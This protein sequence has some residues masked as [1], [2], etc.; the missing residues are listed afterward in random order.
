MK[1]LEK[2]EKMYNKNENK[3][4]KIIDNYDLIR[5]SYYRI[6]NIKFI[7]EKIT[8]L[9]NHDFHFEINDYSWRGRNVNK[10]AVRIDNN[11]QILQVTC[12]CN[13]FKENKSCVHLAGVFIYYSDILFKENIDINSFSLD[14][15]EK[16]SKLNIKEIK[17][18][19]F[20]EVY[21]KSIN[22]NYYYNN[23]FEIKVKI[24][25]NKMYSYGG[26]QSNFIRAY[27]NENIECK[28]G[29]DFIYNKNKNY[30]NP[31]NEIIIEYINNNFSNINTHYYEGKD[32]IKLINKLLENNINFY[33][34]DT[35]ITNIIEEFP[36]NTLIDKIEDNKYKIKFDIDNYIP[37]TDDYKYIFYNDNIYKLSI[38]NRLLVDDL[39]DNDIDNIIVPKEKLELF[40]KSLLPII[41]NNTKVNDNIKEE[42][43][44]I[45]KP[46][47]KLYFDLK[48]KSISCLVK[49]VYNEEINYFDN[50]DN[51]L[52]DSE[53]EQEVINDLINLGF[54]IDNKNKE[55]YIN[56]IENMIEFK[57][58][59]LNI[60]NDKYQVFTTE[61]FD[62]F[63]IYKPS[64]KSM[65]SIG[66][67]NILKY[68]FDLGDID[69]NEIVNI[70]KEIKEKK[71][72]YRLKNGDVLSLEDDKLNELV[73][74]TE[75]LEITDD[76]II[77][78]KGSILKYRAIYLD[79]IKKNKYH[80]IETDN[81]FND[82]IN[83][84][85]KYKDSNIKL[86]D[87]DYKLL[88]DYQVT[89]IKWLYNLDKT[90]FGGIL[91][92]EMGLGKT[93]QTIY[94]IK[95]ILKED[96][97][98]KFLIV[99]PTS[100][101]YNWEHEFNTFAKEIKTT[102]VLG[103]K[104]KRKSLINNKNNVFI[105]TYGLIREDEE[106]YQDK[107]YHAIII[108]EAQNIKNP[109][110]QST[111]AIKKINSNVKF[112]L[113]GTPLENSTIELWSIFDF[114]MPGYLS[115]SKKFNNKYKIND[116]NDKTNKLI[117]GLSNQITPFILR[118]LKKDVIKELP[119]KLENNIYIDLSEGQ[120]K[121]YVA[122]LEKVRKKIDEIIANGQKDK[123]K[124]LILPLL[125]K[126]R[127]I[128]IDP[129]IVYEDYND[130]SNKIDRF[131]SIV[132]ESIK[133][134]H[135]ILVFTSYKS[136]LKIAKEELKK[137]GID[138]LV[139]DGD[140]NAKDRM[141][142]VNSFNNDENAPK[143][144]LIMLKAGGTGL[145]LA[146]ADIVIHLDLWWNPQAENQA[147]DRA[148]RI[149]QK[150]VVNV[151]RL[152]SKGTIEEKVLELQEKK[153]EL[154]NKLLDSN[155]KDQNILST[156][157]EKDILNLL[158]YENK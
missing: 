125:T 14:L 152:I 3:I 121:I 96:K 102:L 20:I 5:G 30:F 93:L 45:N 49:F 120:K 110:A 37:I 135:K 107:E 118:R 63:K 60:L 146:T 157:T 134:N 89:G 41:K 47:C 100:L 136:A 130:S 124:F 133:N 1:L 46:L 33:F 4:R 43:V 26:H 148:H 70:F 32:I 71:K 2:K 104:S 73:N 64:I 51:V 22:N 132:D 39:I 74:L 40:S 29:K 61:K 99:V 150:N 79:S 92:D 27:E 72:Y 97:N 76:E 67:D 81:L 56:D 95:E 87:E 53:Y 62:N 10:P 50:L 9:G 75:E 83:N 138:S 6:N 145:N 111:R 68:N 91:A 36:F 55:L 153:K 35:L 151:I 114:I 77:K 105:T 142:R 17:K 147:T 80:I 42:I 108:D 155:R 149:G 156:L 116:F 21:I 88:R 139:I 143:V 7:N 18:E 28:F 129:K 8:R 84:F 98:A 127:Q 15:L 158:S 82:F 131:L 112:A 54:S 24:G 65:F 58:N 38:K 31:S 119:N 117:D 78:G 103:L 137:I 66:Q 57:T 23:N 101:V 12:N 48:T 16:Y 115:T 144:F 109:L 106:L 126:L 25:E 69:H 13:N 11:N 113:T 140:V 52:R 90:G 59:G 86:N 122:E 44:I 154:S 123:I 128:C 34:N 94:Y 19:V 141:N 85:Y